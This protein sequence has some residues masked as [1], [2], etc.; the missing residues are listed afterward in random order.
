MFGPLITRLPRLGKWPRLAVAACCMLLALDSAATARARDASAAKGSVPVVVAAHALAAGRRLTPS[1]IEVA[2]W[3]ARSRAGADARRVGAVVGRRLITAIGAGEAISSTRLLGR[4]LSTG[5]AA[6]EVAVPVTVADTHAV[7]LL[8]PGDR[9]ELYAIA[10]AADV[11]DPSAAATGTATMVVGTDL[12][13]LAVLP[14]GDAGGAELV[15]AAP[16]ATALRLIHAGVAQA[17]AA[18]AEPP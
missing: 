3:P 18:V 11:F 9:V 17:L 5:L 7:D 15:V 6:G 8:H 14:A 16:R 4:D 1:D 2:H 10:R 12:R 13:V